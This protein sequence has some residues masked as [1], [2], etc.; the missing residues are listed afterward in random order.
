MHETSVI[1]R[2]SAASFLLGPLAAYYLTAPASTLAAEAEQEKVTAEKVARKVERAKK[3]SPQE[4]EAAE[5]LRHF[6]HELAEYAELHAKALRKVGTVESETAQTA[7]AAAITAERRKARQGDVFLVEIQPLFRALLAEQLKGPDTQAARK[8]M[9]EGNPGHDEDSRP[10][11]V[12]VNARY[13]RGAARSTVPPS[14]LL[15]LP[16]LPECLNYLFVGRNLILLDV[17]AQLIVDFLPAATP[18]LIQ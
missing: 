18:E 4:K 3:K 15:A 9:V 14:V 2:R 8:A 6:K 10:V 12:G 7:L 13:P 5:A 16:A 1:T 11:A 17:V